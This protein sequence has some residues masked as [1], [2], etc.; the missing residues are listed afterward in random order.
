MTVHNEVREPFSASDVSRIVRDE[1]IE[2]GTDELKTRVLARVMQMIGITDGKLPER[3][4]TWV[5]KICLHYTADTPLP[6][7]SGKLAEPV[8]LASLPNKK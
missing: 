6:V 5:Y 2:R 7:F 4:R 1:V 3:I 8:D